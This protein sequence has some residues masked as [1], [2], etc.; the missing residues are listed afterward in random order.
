MSCNH[1]SEDTLE[2]FA[3]IQAEL[4]RLLLEE[5]IWDFR[6][7]RGQFDVTVSRLR[8]FTLSITTWGAWLVSVTGDDYPSIEVPATDL[9]G[10]LA[11]LADL[12][13][14]TR[15]VGA[16]CFWAGLPEPLIEFEPEGISITARLS[17]D[18]IVFFEVEL[19]TD[20]TTGQI[21]RRGEIVDSERLSNFED[22][23]KFLNQ[24][25]P[26]LS[27][28][29]VVKILNWHEDVLC[30]E[31]H[32]QCI[33]VHLRDGDIIVAT[34]ETGSWFA[35]GTRLPSIGELPGYVSTVVA[36]ERLG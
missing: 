16:A 13:E 18:V 36:G 27:Q 29:D 19:G 11:W 26:M 5:A 34:N 33:E 28:A 25:C 35:D 24:T 23:A 8:K 21:M 7:S 3:E 2:N 22:L 1:G 15:L 30:V 10:C 6:A 31:Q 14:R 32:P 4:T 17:D 12:E 20:D 9:E